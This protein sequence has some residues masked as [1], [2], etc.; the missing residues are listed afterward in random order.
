[1]N[2]NEK[3]FKLR[4]DK[5]ISQEGLAELMN[6]SRQAVAKWELGSYYPD[7]VNLIALSDIL[8]IHF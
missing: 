8:L 5:G 7:V 4:K 2:F 6:V 1:M 3:L